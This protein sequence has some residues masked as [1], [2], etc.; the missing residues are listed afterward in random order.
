MEQVSAPSSLIVRPE[1]QEVARAI[2]QTIDDWEPI[3]SKR[4]A[5]EEKDLAEFL[6]GSLKSFEVKI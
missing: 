2:L 3:V 6:A 1:S 4:I 5:E